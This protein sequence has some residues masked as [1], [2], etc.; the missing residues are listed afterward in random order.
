[1]KS[2]NE[3]MQDINQTFTEALQADDAKT[4]SQDFR[5]SKDCLS[6]LKNFSRCSRPAPLD[7]NSPLKK[8]MGK[9]NT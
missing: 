5:L 3:G 7:P 1:M 9:N 6:S 2:L 8:M 4:L